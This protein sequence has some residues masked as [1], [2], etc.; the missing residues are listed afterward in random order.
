MITS[1]PMMTENINTEE[2]FASLDRTT[3][4]LLELISS[5]TETQIN[6]LPF[7]GSWTAAQVAEHITLSNI[8]IIKSLKNEGRSSDRSPDAGVEGLRTTFLDFDT[9]L[10]S[11]EFILP[12][13]DI[14]QKKL[15]IDSL[16]ISIAELLRLA[17]QVNLFE[18]ISHPIFGDITKLELIHFVVYHTERHVH[19]LKNILTITGT[20]AKSKMRSLVAFMHVS[21]DGFVANR[22]GEMDWITIDDEIF[23][24]AIALTDITDTALFGRV[25]YKMMESYWPTVLSNDSS[26]E[27]EVQ[28][29]KWMEN[30]SKIV[31]SSTLDKVDW[32]NTR[33]IKENIVQEILELKH[34]PGKSIM[35]FGSPRLTHSFMQWDLIDE[36]RININPVILGGGIPLFSVPARVNLKLMATK[37]FKSGVVGLHYKTIN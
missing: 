17:R 27:L 33:L 30:T 13:R 2:L 28:H 1:S 8:G 14:Y 15:V 10:Q 26:T 29:A 24:D 25:T 21:L 31:V 16:G 11:P 5:F 19:Q 4:E 20:K 18:T 23:K 37:N 12:T 22:R 9:K 34:R 6:E 7:A 35:I 36:Y 32:N 3:L